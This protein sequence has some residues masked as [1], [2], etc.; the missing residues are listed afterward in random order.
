LPEAGI[1]SGSSGAGPEG[2]MLGFDILG[3]RLLRA[4]VSRKR[5]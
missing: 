5:L 3:R 4:D 2:D 1:A